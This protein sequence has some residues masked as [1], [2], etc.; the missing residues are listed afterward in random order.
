VTRPVARTDAV[1]AEAKRKRVTIILSGE[2][3][4]V[5]KYYQKSAIKL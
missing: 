4:D 3:I 5:E 2:C 1:I